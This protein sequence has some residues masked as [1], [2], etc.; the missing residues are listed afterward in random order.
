MI[1]KKTMFWI[2]IDIQW[3]MNVLIKLYLYFFSFQRNPGVELSS[4]QLKVVT[5]GQLT[6]FCIELNLQKWV[7]PFAVQ[8]LE[9]LLTNLEV[10]SHKNFS[11]S[12]KSFQTVS[13][14]FGL[15]ILL[16]FEFAMFC[17]KLEQKLSYVAQY[18]SGYSN[19]LKSIIIDIPLCRFLTSFSFRGHSIT[20]LTRWGGYSRVSNKR[21]R[22]PIISKT[23]SHPHAP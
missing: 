17:F 12:Q 11:F 5:N 7:T 18:C 9:F 10:I 6:I 23:F 16:Q 13:C 19:V 4:I 3:P 14:I 1:V 15:C 22:T 21:D 2:Q 8:Y 20:P